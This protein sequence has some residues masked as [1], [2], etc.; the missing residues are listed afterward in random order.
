MPDK[1]NMQILLELHKSSQIC[2]QSMSDANIIHR[3]DSKNLSC[4][5]PSQNIDRTGIGSNIYFLHKIPIVMT[6]PKASE[7]WREHFKPNWETKNRSLNHGKVDKSQKQGTGKRLE[8]IRSC[9]GVWPYHTCP[10]SPFCVNYWYPN[11]WNVQIL[12]ELHKSSQIFWQPVSGPH[13]SLDP[14][15]WF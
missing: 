5:G 10:S 12:L 9:Q 11:K 1:A 6:I 7:W 8:Q 3:H 13:T 4:F 14:Q 15:A 2:W